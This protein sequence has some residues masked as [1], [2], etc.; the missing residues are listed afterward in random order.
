MNPDQLS[1]AL[2]EMTDL[3]N[4]VVQAIPGAGELSVAEVIEYLSLAKDNRIQLLAVHK[5]LESVK[6]NQAPRRQMA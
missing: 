2:T 5:A 1:A 4:G 6:K 3:L